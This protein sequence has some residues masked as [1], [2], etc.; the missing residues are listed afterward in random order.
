[1]GCL[2]DYT[3]NHC[4]R[5]MFFGDTQT[6]RMPFVADTAQKRSGD[7]VEEDDHT[8][9]GGAAPKERLKARRIRSAREA[10]R[11]FDDRLWRAGRGGG[12]WRSG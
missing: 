10:E 11:L 12:R 4:S 3:L 5:E 8:I 9:P 6:P 1:V 7:G 2:A